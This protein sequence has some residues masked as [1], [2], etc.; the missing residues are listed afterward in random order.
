M[1]KLCFQRKVFKANNSCTNDSVCQLILPPPPAPYDDQSPRRVLTDTEWG[2]LHGHHK[3]HHSTITMRTTNVKWLVRTWRSS[4]ARWFNQIV[5]KVL[6]RRQTKAHNWYKMFYSDVELMENWPYSGSGFR[7]T[8]THER[9]RTLARTC[10]HPPPHTYTH[11]CSNNGFNKRNWQI[12]RKTLG[13]GREV[14]E[15]ISTL[16]LNNVE[17]NQL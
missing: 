7:D 14:L 1:F 16:H 6:G 2:V 5:L 9:A 4:N 8:H 17:T 15:I 11:T 13:V 3:L 10:A 12:S